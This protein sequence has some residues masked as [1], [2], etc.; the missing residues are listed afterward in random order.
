MRKGG[1]HYSRGRLLDRPF[2]GG[3]R[4]SLGVNV[5]APDAPGALSVRLARTVQNVDSPPDTAFVVWA[6]IKQ[7]ILQAAYT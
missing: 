3:A 1:T 7:S 2:I 4:K 6:N 5:K